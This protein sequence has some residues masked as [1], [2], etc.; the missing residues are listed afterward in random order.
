M[1]IGINFHS[2][3][4]YFSGVDYYGLGLIMGLLCIDSVNEYFVF[5]NQ[6]D[7]VRR[8][9]GNRENMRIIGVGRLG[10]RVA[11]IVWEQSRLFLMARRYPH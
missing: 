3:D 1:R 5:T 9:V 11:R 10:G 6:P 8:C 7:A 2:Y 4:E